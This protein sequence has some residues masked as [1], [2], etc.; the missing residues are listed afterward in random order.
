MKTPGITVNPII[1][2]AG[3]HDFN[4]VFF[5]DVRIPREN[6]VD[7]VNKGW[8][9]AMSLLDSE[10]T[11]DLGYAIAGTLLDDI[12]EGARELD[13]LDAENRMRMAELI[14]EIEV[15]RLTH[16]HV[17]WMQEQGKATNMKPLCA[18]CS[19]SSPS[20]TWLNTDE[21]LQAVRAPGA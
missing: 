9:V 12:V 21:G 13:M 10:R 18:S 6:I 20:S 4:E 1:N 17:T 16:Y 2:M 11:S 5:D 19:V 3:H 15:A 8:Y 7:A 14:A